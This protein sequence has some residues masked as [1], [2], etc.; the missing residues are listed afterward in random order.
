MNKGY[1]IGYIRVSTTDQKTA[2]QLDNIQLDKKFIDKASGKNASRPELELMLQFAREGDHIIVH[3]MDRLA[4]NLKDLRNI[5]DS[6][7]SRGIQI[8]FVKENL[9][10]TGKDCPMSTLL[11]S[12]FGSFAE[13]EYSLIRERQMEG[14]AIAKNQGKF[15]GGKKK[16]NSEQIEILKIN[17]E[18]PKSKT[19]IA[20]EM[21][22]CRQTLYRYLEEIKKQQQQK[23]I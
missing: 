21:G 15:V 18:K 16:L 23:V 20:Q 7:T 10:F 22:V 3:S 2:R 1:R 5:V 19:K 12:I 13:F 11:L 6:L 8:E 4:R 9:K 17:L 14:I